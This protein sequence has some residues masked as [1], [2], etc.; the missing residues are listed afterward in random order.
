VWRVA[1]SGDFSD[2]LHTISTEWSL[3]DVVDA[4]T[5]LDSLDEAR[6]RARAEQERR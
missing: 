3:A 5:V 4:N 1:T 6:E 2:S